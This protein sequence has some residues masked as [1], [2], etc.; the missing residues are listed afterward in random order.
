MILAAGDGRCR[1]WRHAVAGM[2]RC[3]L[4]CCLSREKGSIRVTNLLEQG[5]ARCWASIEATVCP[6]VLCDADVSNRQSYSWGEVTCNKVACGVWSNSQLESS[7]NEESNC[8]PVRK[9]FWACEG[10]ASNRPAAGPST[11]GP[12][13]PSIGSHLGLDRLCSQACKVVK[14]RPKLG[15]RWAFHPIQ[16]ER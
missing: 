13:S 4:E 5:M 12:N 14:N 1:A 2:H 16:K 11:P 7:A 8:V 6:L 10:K 9:T 3:L 15:L